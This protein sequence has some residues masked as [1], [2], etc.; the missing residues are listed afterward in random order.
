MAAAV[1]TGRGPRRP[2]QLETVDAAIKVTA[3]AS[4]SLSVQV[5]KLGPAEISCLALGAGQRSGLSSKDIAHHYLRPTSVLGLFSK[6]GNCCEL[7]IHLTGI[8]Y[9]LYSY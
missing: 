2:R 6:K 1:S 3:S 9:N 5:S 7:G 4:F 8:C